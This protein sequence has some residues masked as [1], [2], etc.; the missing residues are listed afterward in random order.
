MTCTHAA[1]LRKKL[2]ELDFKY[3]RYDT[4]ASTAIA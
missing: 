1:I 4:I 3:D 2:I